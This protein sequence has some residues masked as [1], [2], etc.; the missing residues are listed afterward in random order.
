MWSYIHSKSPLTVNPEWIYWLTVEFAH[1]DPDSDQIAALLF[2]MRKKEIG[3]IYRP[4]PVKDNEGKLIGIIGNMF[5]KGST[6]AFTNIDSDKIGSYFTIQSFDVVPEKF[7]PETTLQANTIKETNWDKATTG[8]V[9][10]A[11][12]T[13]VPLPFGK[14]IESTSFDDSFLKEMET[15]SSE[16]GFWARTMTDDI[17]QAN[18]KNDTHTIVGQLLSSRG[19]TRQRDPVCTAT[20]GICEMTATTSPFIDMTLVSAKHNFKQAEV[21]NKII[22]TQLLLA[23]KSSTTMRSSRN[24]AFPFA[25]AACQ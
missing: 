5:D 3:I 9:L 17:E 4:T 6:F 12:P 10:I 21:K 22:P 20:K 14:E 23:S 15:I 19:L 8:I 2:I 24:C 11:L 13:V 1:I 16:H 25:V 18:T 7:C